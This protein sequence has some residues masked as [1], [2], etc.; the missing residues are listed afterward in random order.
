MTVAT[1]LQ[2]VGAALVAAGLFL[3]APW[4][5]VTVLGAFL[6]L[7]GFTMEL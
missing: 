5:G 6:I 4:L 1:A 2:L 3:L 7:F